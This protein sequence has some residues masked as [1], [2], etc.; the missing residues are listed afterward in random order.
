MEYTV[1]IGKP[2][3]GRA[4]QSARIL[5]V[6][7]TYN[8]SENIKKVIDRVLAINGAL[9]V[10]VID[11]SSPDRTSEIV[12]GIAREN[13]RVKLIVRTKK[14]GLGS[15]HLMGFQYGI[16]NGFDSVCTMDADNSHDPNR[17]LEMLRALR[18]ADLVIGSRYVKGG[19]IRNWTLPRKLNSLF[20]N[21]LARFSISSPVRDC[22]SGYRL[23]S[24]ALLTRMNLNSLRSLGYSMIVE[25]LQEATEKGAVIAEVPIVFENRTEGESKMGH[26]EIVESLRTYRRLLFRRK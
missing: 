18:H 17:L 26:V 10:L 24:I 9:Q 12:D 16:E 5:V 2:A 19:I 11:D 8:E 14:L 22:T 3:Y 1:A 13:D 25:L 6:L 23:Y 15:A 4:P 20:A 21:T 7:P